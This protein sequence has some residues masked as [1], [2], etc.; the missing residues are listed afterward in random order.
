MTLRVALQGG[1][2]LASGVAMRLWRAGWQ[3]LITELPQ[4]RAVRRLVSFAQAVYDG[5]IRVEEIRA[6][7]VS[8]LEQ[9]FICLHEHILPVIVDPIAQAA[10]AFHP[11]VWVDGR[12]RKQPPEQTLCDAFF[13]IGL[14]PGFTAGLDCHAV[15]ETNRGPSLGR[16]IYQG[17]A[18]PDT[19]IPEKVGEVQSERVLRAPC[20]GTLT[21]LVEIGA[22]ITSGQPLAKIEQSEITTLLAAPFAGVLRGILQTGLTV[23]PGEKIGDIDPRSDPKLAFFI[24]DKALAVGGG[25][26]EAILAQESLRPLLYGGED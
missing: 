13:T 23:K 25:V 26:I 11:H 5:E 16:V 2:D 1:G 10:R 4:P 17:S 18:Q 15:I 21:T 6:Q 20:T 12:M 14:G 19:G 8:T 7:R 3:V 22:V 9:A 24:S